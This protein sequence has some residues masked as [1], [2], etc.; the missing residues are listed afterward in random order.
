MQTTVVPPAAS[1]GPPV[2][3]NHSRTKIHDLQSH[4]AMIA[5]SR[6]PDPVVLDAQSQLALI[7]LQKHLIRL[8][9]RVEPRC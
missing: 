4:S 8:A 9:C 5:A 1:A 3:S 6:D 2:S 7:R